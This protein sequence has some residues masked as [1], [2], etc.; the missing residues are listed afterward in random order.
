MAVPSEDNCEASSSLIAKLKRALEKSISEVDDKTTVSPDHDRATI[1]KPIATLSE[2][3][4]KTG[5]VTDGAGMEK[6]GK[7]GAI[8]PLQ[9]REKKGMYSI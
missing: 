5:T 4:T 9:K 1:I 6:R 7:E 8:L 3:I 2:N